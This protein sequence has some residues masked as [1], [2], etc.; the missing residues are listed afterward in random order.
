MATGREMTLAD[1]FDLCIGEMPP[2]WTFRISVTNVEADLSMYDPD[3]EEMDI[4]R[5]D[6][7]IEEVVRALVAAAWGVEGRDE[8]DEDDDQAED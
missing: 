6:M 3:G 1:L 5:D 8:P 7:D 4:C 2:G